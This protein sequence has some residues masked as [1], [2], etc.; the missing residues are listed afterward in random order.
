M[1]TPYKTIKVIQDYYFS[2]VEIVE[3][4]GKKYILKSVPDFFAFQPKRQMYLSKRCKKTLIPKI[5]WTKT[6]EGRM[7][8]LME[9]IESDKKT[10]SKSTYIQTLNVLHQE[11]IG[12]ASKLFPV[13]DY[14]VFKNEFRKSKKLI[15]RPLYER[16]DDSLE[17]FKDIFDMRQSVVHGDWVPAQLIPRKGRNYII[18]FEMSF[19]GPSI[20]DH[21]HFFLKDKTID[22][23]FI[24]MM[25]TDKP[26]FLKARIVEVVRKFGWVINSMASGHTKYKFESETKGYVDILERL[27]KEYFI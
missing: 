25:R 19:R 11:T 17:D 21:A 26:M 9:Y 7:Y 24:K 12:C 22:P 6:K 8:F 4:G 18:D 2:K 10:S 20:L 1:K 27:A 3:S 14:A 13:Y 5:K 23:K 15:P 16:L